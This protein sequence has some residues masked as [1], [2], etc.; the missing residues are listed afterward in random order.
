MNASGGA[1][2]DLRAAVVREASREPHTRDSAFPVIDELLG[3]LE[4]GSV[5]AAELSEDGWRV[6]DWVKRGILLGFRIGIDRASSLDPVFHFSDRDTFPTRSAGIG[7][8]I[9]PGGTTVRRGAHLG[10]GVVIM[11]PA[12]VNVGAFVGAGS[13]VDSHALV[14]SCAQIG[15]AVHLS[16]AAQVGGVLEPIGA[17]PV[18]VEDEVFVGGGCGIYEGVQVG[19]GAVLAPGVVVSRSVAI[20][21]LVKGRVLRS[22]ANGVLR[23]PPRAVVVAGARAANGEF[24]RKHGI[25]LQ[26]PVIV[27]YRDT[28][29]DAV[30]AL[31]EALR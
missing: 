27:K 8:R 16:A 28:Q 4:S 25:Q 9:V 24:A 6:N 23:V 10:E 2:S 26:T 29:T 13:M 14:G 11:P 19:A 21:D 31:E 22:D 12:Y 3:A 1:V 30:L 18:I 17:L 7:V 5:R 20:F 15:K